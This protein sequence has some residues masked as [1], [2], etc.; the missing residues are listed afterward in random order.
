MMLED[1]RDREVLFGEYVRSL[2]VAEEVSFWYLKQI[3][4]ERSVH[5]K[6]PRGSLS[7]SWHHC[8]TPA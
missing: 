7:L 2:Q 8:R 6:K 5:G 1:P 3:I 4:D